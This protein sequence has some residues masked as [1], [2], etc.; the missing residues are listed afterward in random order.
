MTTP[1]ARVA[2]IVRTKNRPAMLRRA[3][4]SIRAQAFTDWEC[5]VVNDGGDPAAVDLAIS[6]LEEPVR[7]RVRALHSDESRGR[8]KSANA[9]VLATSAPL[10]TIHDDDDSWDPAFLSDAVGALDEHPERS[11]VVARIEIV[12]EE[13]S[14]TGGLVERGREPFQPHL[15]DVLLTDTLLFNRFVPIGFLYR[16]SLHEELGLY[17]GDLPVIG[18]WSF[19]LRV[20]AREPLHF[21]GDRP[22]A[23]WHQRADSV[24]A[25]GNSVIDARGDHARYDALLRD[26]ALREY[27]SEHGLGLVL[28]LTK[29]I[30]QR[31]VDVENGVRDEVRQARAE[32]IEASGLRRVRRALRRMTRRR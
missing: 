3:L 23:F 5:I 13:R 27:T 14:S 10:L 26:H 22:L 7:S 29:F 30:D 31:F 8:W 2:V 15:G 1:S 19:N 25:D 11:G 16:R 21:V 32:I 17:D 28:Y 20:L 18:D 12:W 6:D 9:G 24:G 4:A